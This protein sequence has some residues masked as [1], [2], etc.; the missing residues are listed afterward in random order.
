MVDTRFNRGRSGFSNAQWN[1]PEFQQQLKDG[2][3]KL[4]GNMGMSMLGCM[5]PNN[6]VSLRGLRSSWRVFT[7]LPR[8]SPEGKYAQGELVLSRFP[9][10][11]T[12]G[13][14]ESFSAAMGMQLH[15][16]P[17]ARA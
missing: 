17:Y 12:M 3:I 11:E 10:L 9:C 1:K 15:R 7:L 16:W 14:Y 6:N 4:R 2:E 13:E 5:Q 8:A